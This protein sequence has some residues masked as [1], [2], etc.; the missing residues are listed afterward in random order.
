MGGEEGS[1]THLI[2]T[3]RPTSRLLLDPLRGRIVLRSDSGIGGHREVDL[4]FGGLLGLCGRVGM[5]VIVVVDAG[6]AGE[7]VGA[8][9]AFLA[10]GIGAHEGFLTGVGADVAGLDSQDRR[11]GG[12]TEHTW[13]SRREN[14]RPQRR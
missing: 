5:G 14:A 9:E 8:G 2:V 7:L 3:V 1:Q 11:H 13:C 4:Y 12:R 6:V 10:G